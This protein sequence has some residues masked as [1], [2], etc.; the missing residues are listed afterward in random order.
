MDRH[1]QVRHVILLFFIKFFLRL[2]IS[3]KHTKMLLQLPSHI[4]GYIFRL[5]RL[6][7]SFESF[8]RGI[9]LRKFRRLVLIQFTRIVDSACNEFLCSWGTNSEWQ[10]RHSDCVS[11]PGIISEIPY[12]MRALNREFMMRKKVI[13][14]QTKV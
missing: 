5:N 11:L 4:L 8:V 13:I 2:Y 9:W 10:N 6:R 7:A 3:I 1:N 14:V 12:L